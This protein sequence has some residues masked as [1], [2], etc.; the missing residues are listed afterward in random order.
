MPF[1]SIPMRHFSI[2]DNAMTLT[3]AEKLHKLMEIFE[4]NPQNT[5]S[6]YQLFMELNKHGMYLTVIRLYH[7]H[8]LNL[9]TKEAELMQ[10]QYD[11][12]KDNI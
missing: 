12:A 11:Y 10:S 3:E 6:S 8:N 1:T 9:I 5:E 2:Q 7:K 4:S